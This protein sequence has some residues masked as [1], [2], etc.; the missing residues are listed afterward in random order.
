MGDPEDNQFK[1]H[2]D[3]WKHYDGL[4]QA[5]TSGF[6][7]A[8][9]ILVAITG[10]L[11]KDAKA[12]ELIVISSVGILVCAS[13]FL[14]LKR[15]GAYIKYHRKIAGGGDEYFWQ[16]KKTGT[17]PSKWLDGTPPVVFF[18]LWVS[19]LFLVAFGYR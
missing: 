5:K 6:L 8:N 1:T 7:T 4:R 17:P 19:V 13:W 14:L 11:F 16:P 10:F 2:I 12:V 9:S 3:M 15:N 18:A